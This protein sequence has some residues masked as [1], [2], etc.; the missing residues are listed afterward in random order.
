MPFHSMRFRKKR[1]RITGNVVI[2]VPSTMGGTISANATALFVIVNPSIFAGG[3]ASDN[4]EAQDKDRTVNVG[5][6]IGTLNISVGIRATTNSGLVEYGLVQVERALATPALGNNNLPTSAE[7]N[8]QGMQQATRMEN[9][10]RVFHWSQRAYTIE[11]TVIQQVKVSPAKYKRS[12]CKA[13]DH[14]ILLVHNR[15]AAQFTIDMQARYKE[16]E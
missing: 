3:N 7:I 5:H 2:H 14:W 11:Q 10:G 16:Y 9:P 12:K 15:G 8:T 4:I 13:G 1:R 6:H